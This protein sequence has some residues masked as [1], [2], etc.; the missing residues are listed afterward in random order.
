[1][2]EP[3]PS[4]ATHLGWLE[5]IELPD[6]RGRSVLDLGCGSGYVCQVLADRGAADVV[7]VDI[8]TP[9]GAPEG[10][11]GDWRFL[12][13]DLEDAAWPQQ[14]A[15]GSSTGRYDTVLCFDILEHVSSPW[16][17]LLGC[18]GLL[19]NRGRLVVTTPNTGSWERYARP[20]GWSGATD[21][22]HK[23]LFN[24]YSLRFILAQAGFSVQQLTAPIRS[25]GGLNRLLP[26][27]GGQLICAAVPTG[28]ATAAR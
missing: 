13:L 16:N 22:Q 15:A 6:W 12:G 27:L 14:A 21:P 4:D 24:A 8:V 10:G 18:H 23:V 7:G 1:M 19:S 5:E 3:R 9:P 11:A 17:F 2:L 28:S 26:H 25:L 20:T